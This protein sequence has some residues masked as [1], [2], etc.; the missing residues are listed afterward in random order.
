MHFLGILLIVRRLQYLPF[1]SAPSPRLCSASLSGLAVLSVTDELVSRV[2]SEAVCFAAWHPARA[3]FSMSV[4]GMVA[5][6]GV[7]GELRKAVCVDKW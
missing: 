2:T 4:L 6:Q 7:T 5:E 3:G 1:S